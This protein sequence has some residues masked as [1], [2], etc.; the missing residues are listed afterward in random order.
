MKKFFADI[1][2]LIML[3]PDT[4]RR[5]WRNSLAEYLISSR[6]PGDAL[7]YLKYWTLTWFGILKFV[8]Q[9]LLRMG[10]LGIARTL[11]KY[12][13]ILVLI[14]VNGLARR[15]V[16]GRSGVF[17][18]SICMT[19]HSVA[20]GVIEQLKDM[21]FYPDRLV[22]NEDL[23]PFDIVQAM[24][25]KSYLLEAWGIVLP[26]L[27][28]DYAIRFIDEAEN[29]GMNPDACS[30]PKTSVGMALKGYLPEGIALV[31]SN[32]PC[33]AGAAS[34]SFFQRKFNVPTY[35]LDVPHN[36]HSKRA[37][38][39]FAKDVRGLIDFLERH[40]PGHMDWHHFR[41]ICER[42]NRMLELELELWDISSIR[43]APLAAE[44]V[45]LSHLWHFN[46]T[47]GSQAS[48][49]H[50][51]KLLE[52]ARKNVK[53]GIP[54]TGKE[55]YRAVLWNP[56]FLHF[57]DIFNWAE[58]TYGLVIIN[59]S[60]TYNH[61]TPID[62]STPESM[63]R[64]WGKTIMHGPMVRNTR[65]PAENYLDDIF[66]MRKQF[67]LDMVWIANH[68]GCKSGQA[69]N[70]IL[71]EKCREKGFPMLVLD[72]DLSDPRIVSRAEMTR[73][74]EHFMDNVMKAERLQ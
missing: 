50:Y 66:R 36:F 28:P 20:M 35:R 34:W 40:T 19:V 6:S 48:L 11:V 65:G 64:D 18:D 42:R 51:E 54:A 59:D 43:P 55:R 68:V 45:W 57:P 67:N 31:S 73:Q 26:L 69:M 44:A 12:P 30:L 1:E 15:F 7:I 27:A 24:G 3:L 39:F 17:H 10:P 5:F 61:H 2:S 70:G 52:M 21:L 63:V 71:R 53:N 8:A 56:P 29:E 46:V 22:V 74:V 32:M 38:S 9:L 58:Q 14:R 4:I 33:D 60:M 16:R 13:W 41:R 47:P 23:V 49:K 25:L 72:Y 37:E 62:T